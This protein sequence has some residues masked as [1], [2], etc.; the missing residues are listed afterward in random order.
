MCSY[1]VFSNFLVPFFIPPGWMIEKCHVLHL[2]CVKS[3]ELETKLY[4][5][6]PLFLFLWPVTLLRNIFHVSFCTIQ[7][8]EEI[9]VK[10]MF[11]W[12]TVK[13]SVIENLKGD[14]F[15]LEKL[16]DIFS[17]WILCKLKP[18]LAQFLLACLCNYNGLNLILQALPY[19]LDS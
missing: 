15:N 1:S 7:Q 11:Q 5:L 16:I 3:Y 6:L 10:N 19:F 2:S 13:D 17:L 8:M 12:S 9:L 14:R 4:V 18:F